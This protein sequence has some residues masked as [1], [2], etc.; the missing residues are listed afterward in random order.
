MRIAFVHKTVPG[1]HKLLWEAIKCVRSFAEKFG[2]WT[3][4]D[5]LSSQIAIAYGSDTPPIMLLVAL[6]DDERVRSH[7]IA[8]LDDF[9]GSRTMCIL[10][11]EKDKDFDLPAELK[12]E[13]IEYLRLW[14]THNGV[15]KIR[16]FARNDRVAQLFESRYGFT[17]DERVQMTASFDDI[18]KIL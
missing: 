12:L 8:V 6:D 2:T 17:R 14:A 9:F 1:S 5:N 15:D 3:D 7:L 10:Q 13:A 11:W 16:I 4:I 18:T